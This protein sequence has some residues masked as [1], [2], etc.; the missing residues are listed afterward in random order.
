MKIKKYNFEPLV[1]NTS[2][3]Q[4]QTSKQFEDSIID[5]K[6][7]EKIEDNK[8][9]EEQNDNKKDIKQLEA[10]AWQKGYDQAKQEITQNNDSSAEQH[11]KLMIKISDQIAEIATNLTELNKPLTLELKKL[12][13]AIA[14]K[15]IKKDLTENASEEIEQYINKYLIM[16]ND[17]QELTIMVNPSLHQ[18][19]SAKMDELKDK[20]GFKGHIDVKS[21]VRLNEYDCEV[22]WQNGMIKDDRQRIIDEIEKLLN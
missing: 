17:E 11:D 10:A 22:S 4:E 14:K 18:A 21:D 13:L 2:I 5:I 9:Q 15:I 12:T 1:E 20:S 8:L 19:I 3:N 16:L 7:S 6:K